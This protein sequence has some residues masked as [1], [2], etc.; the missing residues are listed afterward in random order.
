[1]PSGTH[2]L[3]ICDFSSRKVI[4]D[5]NGF[6]KDF[7]VPEIRGQ[8]I[9]VSIRNTLINFRSYARNCD[10][11]KEEWQVF[12]HFSPACM[13]KDLSAQTGKK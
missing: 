13:L 5:L 10:E 2:I 3:N 12:V 8:G 11:Y 7:V 1:M 6:G 9:D 4:G